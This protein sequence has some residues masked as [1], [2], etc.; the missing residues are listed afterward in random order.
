MALEACWKPVLHHETFVQTHYIHNVMYLVV[1]S[2]TTYVVLQCT[3]CTVVLAATRST[4]ALM[5]LIR[6]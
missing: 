5:L 6:H 1:L 3:L 2:T 4:S